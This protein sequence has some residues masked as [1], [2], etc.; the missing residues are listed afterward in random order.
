[1]KIPYN[2]TRV[3]STNELPGVI[4]EPPLTFEFI[5]NPSFELMTDI[6]NWLKNPDWEA[7]KLIASELI[8]AVIIPD[9]TKYDLGTVEIIQEFADET[10]PSFIGN[11]I[12]GWN[13]R[14][15]L[16]RMASVKKN[17]HSSRLLSETNNVK[18]LA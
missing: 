11:L 15:S 16:E 17:R 1:M 9:G 13:T 7:T 8:Q 5:A 14:I 18:N 3:F 4:C 2:K 6:S 12:N 10:E